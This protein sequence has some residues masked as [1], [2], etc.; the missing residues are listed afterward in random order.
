VDSRKVNKKVIEALI[1]CGAFDS[2]PGHRA[3]LLA[4]LEEAMEVG[5][6]VRCEREQGQE[7]LFATAEIISTNG[8]S[9]QQLPELEEWPEKIRLGFEKEALG[10]YITGHPMAGYEAVVKR[11]ASCDAAGLAERTDREEIAVCGIVAAIKELNTKKGERMAFVSLEDLSGCAEVVV[12]P[13]VYKAGYEALHEEE[14]VL[15]RG[16]L[17]VGEES[18]KLIATEIAA[19]ADYQ[20]RRARRVRFRLSAPAV[21]EDLLGDLRRILS[22]H[23]GDCEAMIHVVIPDRSEAVIR[24]PGDLKV[25]A[26]DEIMKDTEKLF[27]YS[28]TTFE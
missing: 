1:K 10:F 26:C 20:R 12:F 18:R 15:V 23:P 6:K 17:D 8:H 24:L 14:P 2:L 4:G 3:Q 27:G 13:E 22:E 28:V 16:S 19:L 21:D 25:A 9:Y 7:S 5:H 11:F